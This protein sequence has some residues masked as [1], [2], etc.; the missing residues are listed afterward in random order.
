LTGI[1]EWG[2]KSLQPDVEIWG[3]Y[4]PTRAEEPRQV[5]IIYVLLECQECLGREMAALTVPQYQRLLTQSFLPRPCRKCRA[6]RDCRLGFVEVAVDEVSPSLPAAGAFS[7]TAR[8]APD[9][10]RDKRLMVKLPLGIRLAD[11]R[12]E[13][14]TTENLSKSGFSFACSLEMQK[15]ELVQVRIGLDSPREVRDVPARILWRRL[16]G[17]QGRSFYGAKLEGGG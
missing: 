5:D 13:T 14:S 9:R 12:E 2:V 4:F 17:E 15:G 1:P 10:R 7:L 11:G 6:T 8:E 3:V 16:S